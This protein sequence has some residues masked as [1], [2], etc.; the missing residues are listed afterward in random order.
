MQI[1][2]SLKLEKEVAEKTSLLIYSGLYLNAYFTTIIRCSV[3][4][5]PLKSSLENTFSRNFTVKAC[6][7]YFILQPR[8]KLLGH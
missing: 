6:L 7:F 2:L 3:F 5:N 8:S 4:K 1:L